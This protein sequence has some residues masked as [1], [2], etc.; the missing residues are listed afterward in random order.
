MR[1]KLTTVAPRVTLVGDR[2]QVVQ[3]AREGATPRVRGRRWMTR[4]AAFLR[5]NSLCINLFNKHGPRAATQVDHR[6]PLADGGADHESN[7]QSLCDDCHEVKTA[8][9]ARARSGAR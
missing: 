1:A 5:S 3:P 8:A 4:R 9:E 2:L 7:Y 6:I